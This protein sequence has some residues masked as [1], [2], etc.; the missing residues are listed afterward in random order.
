MV[1]SL[2][3]IK[4]AKQKEVIDVEEA[5]NLWDACRSMYGIVERIQIWQNFAHDYEF[6]LLFKRPL[7]ISMKKFNSWKPSSK[8]T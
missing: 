1:F 7:M 2:D 5:Y 4:E 3:G 6:R 8:N